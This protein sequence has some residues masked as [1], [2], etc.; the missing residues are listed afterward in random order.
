MLVCL[1]A[2]DKYNTLKHAFTN[3]LGIFTSQ[4]TKQL[5]DEENIGNRKPLLYPQISENRTPQRSTILQ[6]NT[7]ESYWWSHNNQ[8]YVTDVH[9]IKLPLISFT[10]GASSDDP[11]VEFIF[12]LTLSLLSSMVTY[13]RFAESQQNNQQVTTRNLQQWALAAASQFENFDFK[14]LNSW[15]EKFKHRHRIGQRKIT[16]YVSEKESATIEETLASA[17]NFRTQHRMTAEELARLC[18]IY[19]DKFSDQCEDDNDENYVLSENYE[20]SDAEVLTGEKVP[21]KTGG[22]QQRR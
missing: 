10:K 8:N 9:Q 21:I 13:D 4:K 17:E 20:K 5:L 18:E 14:A 12:A 15:V 6:V 11:K 19:D 2:E 22:R 16:K 7:F 3:R 1:P